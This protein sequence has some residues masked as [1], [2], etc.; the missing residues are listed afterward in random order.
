MRKYKG[1]EEDFWEAQKA[2]QVHPFK[3]KALGDCLYKTRM[4]ISAKN[5]GKRGGARIIYI[6]H[7]DIRQIYVLHVYDKSVQEDLTPAQYKCFRAIAIQ[8]YS[9]ILARIGIVE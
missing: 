4:S 1:I 3:E 2:I 9:P 8:L 6:A 5:K 7:R